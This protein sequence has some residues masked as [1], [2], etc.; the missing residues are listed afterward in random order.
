MIYYFYDIFSTCRTSDSQC[1]LSVFILNAYSV[2]DFIFAN[3]NNYIPTFLSLSLSL[4]V[5]TYPNPI[6]IGCNVSVIFS[7][8]FLLIFSTS[9]NYDYGKLEGV[10]NSTI[11]IKEK[12]EIYLRRLQILQVSVLMISSPHAWLNYDFCQI[13]EPVFFLGLPEN[14]L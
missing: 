4:P 11:L 2:T 9:C 8:I 7:L 3:I 13:T 1:F 5:N 10:F 6:S 14:C 12:H